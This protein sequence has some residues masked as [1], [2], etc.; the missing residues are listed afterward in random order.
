MKNPFR[1]LFAVIAGVTL[2]TQQQGNCAD[3]DASIFGDTTVSGIREW[4]AK[5]Q[6][7]H[8]FN[9]KRRID[10]SKL[11]FW[12]KSDLDWSCVN[13]V[14]PDGRNIFCV[15]K[16]GSGDNSATLLQRASEGVILQL[17]AWTAKQEFSD[18]A[19]AFF[20]QRTGL[21]ASV[22]HAGVEF[23]AWGD[24]HQCVE[25]SLHGTDCYED[26]YIRD[27]VLHYNTTSRKF[28]VARGQRKQ[29]EK[30]VISRI[31]E[32][33]KSWM[34]TAQQLLQLQSKFTAMTR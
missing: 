21:A 29:N 19:W 4:F 12:T 7:R 32:T 17:G 6:N 23:V 1:Y 8:M 31:E 10:P 28:F 11:V 5:P 3:S 30:A 33:N 20:R 26:Y 34:S 22:Y 2:A 25:F 15:Q 27:W 18:Q 9:S 24:D 13:H 16:T 14:S